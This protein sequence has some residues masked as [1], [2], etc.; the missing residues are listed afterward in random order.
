MAIIKNLK[1]V[2]RVNPGQS[3]G[4]GSRMLTQVDLGQRKDGG[5]YCRGLETS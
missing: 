2:L 5:G 1:L 4:Y 3:P